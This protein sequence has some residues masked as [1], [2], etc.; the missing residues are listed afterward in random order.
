LL[1]EVLALTERWQ[2]REVRVRTLQQVK[3]LAPLLPEQQADVELTLKGDELR[4]TVRR[5][6]EPLALGAFRLAAE[7][8]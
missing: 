4:F 2:Q 3:F 6:S 7:L 8:P 1:D 5:D